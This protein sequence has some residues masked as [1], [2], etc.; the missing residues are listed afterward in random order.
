MNATD[1]VVIGVIALILVLA[2]TKIIRDKKKGVKCI[3]CDLC[4]HAHKH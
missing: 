3:G 4:D 2:I 1:F